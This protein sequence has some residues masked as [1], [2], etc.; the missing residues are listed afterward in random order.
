MLLVAI[1]LHEVRSIRNNYSARLRTISLVAA[2]MR[3]AQ[4]QEFL[5]LCLE[6]GDEFVGLDVSFVLGLFGISQL[7]FR[8]LVGQFLDSRAKRMV[9]AIGYERQGLLDVKKSKDWIG[10]SIKCTSVN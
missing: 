2:S 3:L 5:C 10:A 4:V 1:D 9:A 7:A 8:I 6:N